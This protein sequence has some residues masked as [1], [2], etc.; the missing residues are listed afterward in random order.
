MAY[1]SVGYP[2]FYTATYQ[3]SPPC[4]LLVSSANGGYFAV[5]DSSNNVLYIRWGRHAASWAVLLLSAPFP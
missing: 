3:G 2:I 1:N 4:H 5:L